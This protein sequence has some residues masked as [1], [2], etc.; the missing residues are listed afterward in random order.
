MMQSAAT[1]TSAR[2]YRRARGF[3]LVELIIAVSISALIG[4]YLAGKSRAEAEESLAK[5]SATYISQVASAAQQHVLLN[6]NAYANNTA[7][8]GVA[9]LLRPTVAELR[10]LG[11]LNPG[12]P[13][14]AGSL[15]TRQTLRIDITR[16]TCPGATCQVQVLAC[17]TNAVTLGGANVRFDLA[18]TMTSEQG[19][20]GGQAL[21]G[22]GNIIRGPALNVA[23][24]VGNVPGV[25]CGSGTVDTALF[26]RFLIV[27]DTRDP[28][29]QGTF[30]LAGAATLNG[31]ATVQ[32]NTTVRNGDVSVQNAGG[33]TTASVLGATGRAGFRGTDATDNPAGWNGGVRSVDVVASGGVLA[34]TAPAAFT[35][36]N[37]DYAYV[38][39]RGG[40]GEVRTSGR[41]VA[42][43]L[44]PTGTYRAGTACSAADVGAIAR[45]EANAGNAV[46]NFEGLV[47]CHQQTPGVFR[48]RPLIAYSA[49]GTACS[50]N[51][52]I[53]DTGLGEKLL[54]SGGVW[55]SMAS[56]RPLATPG[57]ACANAG[58]V[59]YDAA[60][61]DEMLICRLNPAG[62]S[63][64]WMRV[65]D[66]TSN[67][68]FV[69]A[70]EVGD[71]DIVTKPTCGPASGMTATPVLQLIGKVWSSPDGGQAF[72]AA[73]S[74]T[75]W[76]IRLR[77][78]TFTPLAGSPEA[79]AIA[80]VFC[81]FA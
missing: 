66:L 2:A 46:Q 7:V 44:L 73:E 17:T 18:S 27:N 48:W 76:T 15:P 59:A 81:Y 31:G 80:N 69:Q 43:R 77:N 14:A 8:A 6:W 64:R 38:G 36:A 57:A 78:G 74:A 10:T 4:M 41:A 65:R 20:T 23:N 61:G 68:Q 50:P 33:V 11:R 12:F 25:V 63:E 40:V 22:A 21:Q 19:G 70:Y 47:T 60:S 79:R 37:G 29:F 30:T 54:C 67:L 32:G 42:D 51:G 1:R 62:G 39:V 52:A 26:E 45:A 71:N 9:T 56:L 3:T 75:R 49:A 16:N 53:G 28:N 34:S 55:V 72:V 24:P 5:G 58:S 35:G 13:V